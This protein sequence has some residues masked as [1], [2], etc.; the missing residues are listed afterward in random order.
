MIFGRTALRCWPNTGNT[1]TD[2][3][4]HT[5]T[6]ENLLNP[7]NCYIAVSANIAI[8]WIYSLLRLLT[9]FISAARMLWKLTVNNAMATDK[10]PASR[11]T[12]QR[13]SVW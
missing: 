3:A 6:F 10:T 11:N 4:I 7:M 13:M 9:G 1:L 8:P 12:H 5:N 2:S